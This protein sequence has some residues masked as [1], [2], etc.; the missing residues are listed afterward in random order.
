MTQERKTT[1]HENHMLQPNQ[2][3]NSVIRVVH[4]LMILLEEIN[5]TSETPTKCVCY[6]CDGL[7]KAKLQEAK[8]CQKVGLRSREKGEMRV[9]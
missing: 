7:L 2:N 1:Q 3:Q 4:S 9:I 8:Q 5:M 6:Q